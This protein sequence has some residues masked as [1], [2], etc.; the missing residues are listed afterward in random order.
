MSESK[1]YLLVLSLIIACLVTGFTQ[2]RLT[3]ENSD[4]LFPE[5]N[6]STPA[7][8]SSTE[9]STSFN[10]VP[11]FQISSANNNSCMLAPKAYNY[12]L[13]GAFCKLDV[14]L[15]KII[16]MPVKFRLGTVNYVDQMEG[17]GVKY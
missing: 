16:Q 9:P 7:L 13:L 1:K 2:V 8:F 10:Q 14:Q 6:N 4:H 15:E 5:I 3:L 12:H 17:K 11:N